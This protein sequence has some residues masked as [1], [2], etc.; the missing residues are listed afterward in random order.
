MKKALAVLLVFVMALGTCSAMAD[1]DDDGRAGDKAIRIPLAQQPEYTDGVRTGRY[2]NSN[3]ANSGESWQVEINADHTFLFM[4]FDNIFIGTWTSSENG[5]SVTLNV[6]ENP[7]HNGFGAPFRIYL[8]RDGQKSDVYLAESDLGVF[9]RAY[10][11]GIEMTFVDSSTPPTGSLLSNNMSGWAKA[12]VEKA[13]TMGLIPDSL[14]NP[15]VDYTNPITRAEFAAVSVKVY[16]SLSGTAALP[17]LTNPFTD[18]N[19]VEV[20][21]A[22]NVGITSGTGATTFSPNTLLNREQAATML[23][24]VFKKATLPGWTLQTD[25]QFTLP[26][27]MPAPFADDVQI[28]DYAKDSVYFMAANGIIGGVG[29]NMFAPRAVTT[30]EQARGYA[31]A[32]REQALAIA[33]RMVENLPVSR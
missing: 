16:E 28:S 5:A 22:Y 11:G 15:S 23:T 30:E 8:R 13:Y 29:N 20:L 21:K 7:P 33:V 4:Y 32:T 14:L 2:Y 25:N 18:T 12:E 27:V 31:T 6:T 3:V 26:F 19:D 9:A 24:R 1:F 10:M 17:A